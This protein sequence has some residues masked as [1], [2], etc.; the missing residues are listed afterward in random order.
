MDCR[1][2]LLGTLVGDLQDHQSVGHLLHRLWLAKRESAS[3]LFCVVLLRV[4]S[5]A[6]HSCWLSS[7]LL[8]RSS[9]LFEISGFRECLRGTV[10]ECLDQVENGALVHD[11]LE[12]VPQLMC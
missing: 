12:L 4:C 8:W 9:V 3:V 2:A 10:L 5:L 7:L 11:K 1:T 6:H